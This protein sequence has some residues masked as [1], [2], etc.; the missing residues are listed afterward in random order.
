MTKAQEAAEKIQEAYRRGITHDKVTDVLAAIIEETTGLSE[1]V[2][3]L[4]ISFVYR[5]HPEMVDGD[6]YEEN[7]RAA[8][9]RYQEVER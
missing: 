4:G 5:R 2:N 7:L 9:A 8:L 1:L 6:G 3:L